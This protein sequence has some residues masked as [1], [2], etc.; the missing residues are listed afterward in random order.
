MN[1][2]I[3]KQDMDRFLKESKGWIC[4][5][6]GNEYIYDFHLSKYPIIVK[7]ASSLRIDPSLPRNKNSECIR[8]FSVKKSGLDVKDKIVSGLIKNTIVEK[9]IN[10]RV[11]LQKEV[12][13][14]IRRS[15]YVYTKIE[16]RQ[17]TF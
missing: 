9:T 15:K 16:N 14:V 4:N 2:T 1:E 13:S 12:E 17:H 6:L 3:K 7:V 8:V 11:N 10:W 5:K